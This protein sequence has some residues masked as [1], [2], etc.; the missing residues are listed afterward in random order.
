MRNATGVLS[1]V[2]LAVILAGPAGASR[3]PS[4]VGLWRTAGMTCRA[5]EDVLTSYTRYAMSSDSR[6]C[7][8]LRVDGRRPKWGLTL[9]CKSVGEGQA[10]SIEEEV[11]LSEDA[12]KLSVVWQSPDMASGG[13]MELHRCR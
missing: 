6:A 5:P 8:I 3:E 1:L 4:Y 10:F 2:L 7:R 13:D 11:T 9:D 12:L